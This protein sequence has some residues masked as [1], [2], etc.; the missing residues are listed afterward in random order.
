MKPYLIWI[1]VFSLKLSLETISKTFVYKGLGSSTLGFKYA[2]YYVP[3]PGP[4]CRPLPLYPI[5]VSVSLC[6]IRL[7]K[8]FLKN[9]CIF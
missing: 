9:L 1:N 4:T 2:P 6:S 8:V 7:N 3:G 5:S